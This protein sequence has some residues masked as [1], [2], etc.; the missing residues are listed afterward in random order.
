VRCERTTVVIEAMLISCADNKLDSNFKNEM[1]VSNLRMIF[2]FATT[3]RHLARQVRR[4][5]PCSLI[6]SDHSSNGLADQ[7]YCEKLEREVPYTVQFLLDRKQIPDILIGIISDFSRQT[8][9][10]SSTRLRRTFTSDFIL[11]SFLD[12]SVLNK[13]Q[14]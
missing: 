6:Y 9:S 7:A 4:R 5:A 14:P 12:G 1:K 11:V 10:R 8:A 3:H 13:G 2:K